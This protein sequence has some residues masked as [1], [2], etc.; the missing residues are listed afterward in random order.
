MLMQPTIQ[1][2][3]DLK[4][5]GMAEAFKSLIETPESESISFNDRFSLVV[6]REYLHRENRKQTRL[7]KN[8][9]LRTTQACVEDI[10]YEHSRGL[11]KGVMATLVLC[12]WIRR[13]H[14][15]IFTRPTGVGKTFLACA[16]GHQSC[17]QGLSVQYFR[18]SKLFEL[19]KMHHANG[20][21]LQ[22]TSQIA[23]TDVIILDDWGLGQLNKN[24]RHE[25]LEI[26]ED[27]HAL[28]STVITSQLPISLW[29]E[30][31]GDATIADAILDR[32]LSSAHKIDLKGDSLRRK[33]PDLDSNRSDRIK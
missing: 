11:D 3:K 13:K 7:L 26:L 33:D 10:D 2:L 32:L 17:R 31:I 24:D 14:N 20:K 21:H 15:L 16:L 25:L 29:H 18:M 8:A 5:Y 27:R 6:D 12:D 22:L 9:K 28:K 1:K 23:K 30:Y 4:L 19:L